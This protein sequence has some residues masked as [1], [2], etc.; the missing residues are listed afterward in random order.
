MISP[1][2]PNPFQ[3]VY[4]VTRVH[5]LWNRAHRNVATLLCC[6]TEN[7]PHHRKIVGV[8]QRIE[9]QLNVLLGHGKW[10]GSTGQILLLV[11]H[12]ENSLTGGRGDI[13]PAIE[14][15]RDGRRRYPRTLR[16][17]LQGHALRPCAHLSTL[18]S[19]PSR[20]CILQ[21]ESFAQSYR[22]R[23]PHKDEPDVA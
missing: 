20:P 11:E 8:D 6:S 16:Y 14:N 5:V 3:L 10:A 21:V 2:R 1:T 13:G 22:R 12:S 23:Q 17:L 7:S 18:R 9:H 15:L 19:P 4:P